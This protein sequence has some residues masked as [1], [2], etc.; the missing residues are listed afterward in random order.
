[1]SSEPN[2]VPH[3]YRLLRC[4]LNILLSKSPSHPCKHMYRNFHFLFRSPLKDSYALAVILVRE[5]AYVHSKQAI[6]IFLFHLN[7]LSYYVGNNL[8]SW[9]CVIIQ[10]PGSTLALLQN[11][12]YKGN[13]I[14]FF[15]YMFSHLGDCLHCMLNAYSVVVI[16]TGTR[17]AVMTKPQNPSLQRVQSTTEWLKKN[18]N[19]Q[20]GKIVL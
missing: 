20:H 15:I 16:V 8:F 10:P 4:V 19:R 7:F 6:S 3:T 12:L 18:K 2:P 17:D 11:V 14:H 13:G 1:M 9:L 5:K